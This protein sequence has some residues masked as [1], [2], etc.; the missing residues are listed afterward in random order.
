M[1]GGCVNLACLHS[2]T[3][4]YGVSSES[5]AVGCTLDGVVLALLA[6]GESAGSDADVIRSILDE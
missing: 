6:V 5:Y 2:E 1:G 3:T 4:A